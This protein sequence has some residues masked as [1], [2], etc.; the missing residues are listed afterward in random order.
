MTISAAEHSP[1]IFPTSD[2]SSAPTI[3]ERQSTVSPRSSIRR[4]SSPEPSTSERVS[5]EAPA[6]AALVQRTPALASRNQGPSLSHNPVSNSRRSSAQ[7]P[8]IAARDAT[9]GHPP[10]RRPSV[11]ADHRFSQDLTD[12]PEATNDFANSNDI[13][14]NDNR[15][16]SARSAI[17]PVPKDDQSLNTVRSPRKRRSR[18]CSASAIDRTRHVSDPLGQS[19]HSARHMQQQQ[20]RRP[21]DTILRPSSSTSPNPPDSDNDVPEVPKVPENLQRQFDPPLPSAS[22]TSR[23]SSA[24][25]RRPMSMQPAARTASGAAS[26]NVPIS[27]LSEDPSARHNHALFLKQQRAS[28]PYSSASRHRMIGPIPPE[29]YDFGNPPLSPPP[30]CPLPSVPATNRHSADVSSR[31]QSREVPPSPSGPSSRRQSREIPG[32]PRQQSREWKAANGESAGG[33]H[34]VVSQPPAHPQ[35]AARWSSHNHD[36]AAVAA[37]E[38]AIAASS[39]RNIKRKSI[40][41]VVP[42][43]DDVTRHTDDLRAKE[44]SMINAF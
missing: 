13:N 34:H 32:S 40:P 16:H 11:G 41:I 15:R 21:Q 26:T 39:D 6:D 1:N 38:A 37:K 27:S 43:D 2:H 44:M 31:R 23:K 4:R 36:D 18:R 30:S 17:S 5:R 29:F 8:S 12:I 9:Q 33:R 28:V 14:D 19:S 10:S 20:H 35:Y 42:P 24:K 3:E 7:Q 25:S 22:P